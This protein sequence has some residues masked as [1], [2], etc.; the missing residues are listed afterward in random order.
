MATTTMVDVVTTG[1]SVKLD[2]GHLDALNDMELEVSKYNRQV[3]SPTLEGN[4]P[5]ALTGNSDS[6]DRRSTANK[7]RT[8]HLSSSFSLNG[9]IHMVWDN[10]LQCKLSWKVI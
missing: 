1:T 6:S 4:Q 5:L 9:N 3:M 2:A 7:R 8:N 10:Y